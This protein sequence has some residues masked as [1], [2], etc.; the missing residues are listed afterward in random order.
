VASPHR[1]EQARQVEKVLHEIEADE[2]PRLLVLNKIDRL[3]AAERATWIVA[4]KA[5][6]SGMEVVAVSALTGEGLPELRAAL[7]RSPALEPVAEAHFHFGPAEG[8]KL[9]FLHEH[10]QVRETRYTDAGVEV[11]ATVSDSVRRKLGKHVL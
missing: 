6:A 1:R 2:K 3:P 10:G 4:E 11:V 8:D 5:A 9:S 7:D